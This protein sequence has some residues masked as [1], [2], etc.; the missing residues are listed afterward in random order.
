MEGRSVGKGRFTLWTDP[1]QIH[2]MLP[3][4]GSVSYATPPDWSA[5]VPFCVGAEVVEPD[6]KP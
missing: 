1:S 6:Q 2:V 3:P 5:P 4:T